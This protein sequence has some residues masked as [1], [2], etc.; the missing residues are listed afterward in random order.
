MNTA[1]NTYSKLCQ[2]FFTLKDNL[3]G[4]GIDLYLAPYFHGWMI[5]GRKGDMH[6]ADSAI[7][8]VEL[9]IRQLTEVTEVIIKAFERASPQKIIDTKDPDKD[10]LIDC[11]IDALSRFTNAADKAE[12]ILQPCTRENMM[13]WQSACLKT[14]TYRL[15]YADIQIAR[16]TLANAHKLLGVTREV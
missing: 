8:I 11:L 13:E 7:D 1:E 4:V 16:Q 5:I 15:S 9:D 6:Y 3:A 10:L 2:N 14:M 12:K